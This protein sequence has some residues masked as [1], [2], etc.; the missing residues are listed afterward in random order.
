MAIENGQ[1]LSHY[2]L[3]EKIGEGGMG[4][5]WKALDTRLD[6]EVAL[7]LLPSR[8]AGDP[9][10]LARFEREAR[11]VAALSHPHILAVH[12]VGSDDGIHFVVM[13]L[14]KG[15]TLKKR[16][17]EGPLPLRK[18]VELAAQTARG[19]AAAHDKGIVHRD[20]KPDNL[21]VTGDGQI[22]ILDFGLAKLDTAR[23][24]ARPDSEAATLTRQTDPGVV[25]GTVGYM[26]PEQVRGQE[27]DAR[28]DIFALGVVLYEMVTGKRAFSGDSSVETMNAILKE[29]P[30]ALQEI[31][32]EVSP[33]LERIIR[34]C[35]EKR[36]DERFQSVRD[37]AFDLEAHTDPSSS[38]AV[39]TL[40][41]AEP[42]PA[43][44]KLAWAAATLLLAGI[45][46][47]AGMLLG[48]RGRSF[49]LHRS[50]RITH[51]EGTVFRARF[52]GDGGTVVFSAS[53]DGEPPRLFVK[54]PEDMV[55]TPLDL[56]AGRLVSVSPS[57]ELAIL[58][59]T[60]WLPWI[61]GTLAR[62]ALSDSEPR[63]LIEDV[64]DAD[65]SLDGERLAIVREIEGKRRLEFPPGTTLYETA[66]HVSHP[67][68]SPGGDRIAY[69]DHPRFGDTRGS[70]AVVDLQGN[71][72]TLSEGWQT[73]RALAWSPSG[74]EV[75]FTSKPGSDLIAVTLDGRQR[76]VARSLTADMA[77]HDLSPG[78]EALLARRDH[79]LILRG[80][81]P[82]ETRER[83]LSWL[84]RSVPRSISADGT[85]LL[86]NEQSEA[87]GLNYAV[88]LRKM[89]GSTPVR[90]GEGDARSL[91][92]DGKWALAIP[93]DVQDR[94][95]LLP[96]GA[97]EPRTVSLPGLREAVSF[98]ADSDR[99]VV[100]VQEEGKAP[101][102]YT[103][104][105]DGEDLRPLLP[106]GHMALA[107]PMNGRW[108]ACYNNGPG[109]LPRWALGNP[110]RLEIHP[111]D[112]G[113]VRP[114]LGL[115]PGEMPWRWSADGRSI[116][117]LQRS[118][119]GGS[120]FLVDHETGERVLWKALT[121]P[122]R[123]GFLTIQTYVVNP[124]GTAYAYSYAR[125]LAELFVV[126]GL[127]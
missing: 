15:E 32:R 90:L 105:F 116:Y 35:L 67:R 45:A 111:S 26:S 96:T 77:L 33:A 22:K 29:E 84:E 1:T 102:S 20:L 66:G 122:D 41:A 107:F 99:V 46:L 114:I 93:P 8:V 76:V 127:R 79:R 27:A 63:E 109:P 72:E 3:I 61:P 85:T 126:E 18:T 38:G 12:D 92:P 81:G 60:I 124:E 13:E 50:E 91:S 56:K 64:Y 39:D 4:S 16:I 100:W 54:R 82:G 51:R 71:R 86:F 47:A 43:I 58:T 9:R 94:F 44:R 113:E 52:V 48:G 53:W 2:R 101:R 11:A 125:E 62:A 75:W 95:I 83:N 21:F 88:A 78:G 65:W 118:A 98:S 55:A 74:D 112:G 73:L 24:G 23:A 42:R 7:K 120:L 57:G 69:L 80:L 70:V 19:L 10:A 97:G 36:P 106:E 117:V 5:V 37:V 115:R 119:S 34:H 87:I 121:P 17:A 40:D 28:S 68:F 103:V 31:S 104:D 49:E 110:G 123:T 6:R 89:D 25:L 14:L 59:N 30:P 108:I